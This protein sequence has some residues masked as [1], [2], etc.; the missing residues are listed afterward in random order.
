LLVAIVARRSG[1]RTVEKAQF[2]S[3]VLTLA[4]ARTPRRRLP[5]GTVETLLGFKLDAGAAAGA[6][7]ST[8]ITGRNLD[9]ASG[10]AA[11]RGAVA[12]AMSPAPLKTFQ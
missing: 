6:F 5:A 9:E 1:I 10:E 3:T 11:P 7:P 2:S 4:R 8:K 12:A